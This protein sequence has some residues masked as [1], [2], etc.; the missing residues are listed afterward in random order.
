MRWH[1][2]VMSL[3]NS[4]LHNSGNPLIC[5]FDSDTLLRHTEEK[6]LKYECH[7]LKPNAYTPQNNIVPLQIDIL[8]F[9]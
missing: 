3:I 2:Y 8:T 5:V 6:H 9:K 4:Y 7:S 1:I